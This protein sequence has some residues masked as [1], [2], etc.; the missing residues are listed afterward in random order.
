MGEK[1]ELV[2]NCI[3]I[4]LDFLKN[5]NSVKVLDIIIDI[6]YDIMRSN[7]DEKSREQKLLKVL[8][9]LKNSQTFDSM[10]EEEDR[11]VLNS[12]LGDFLQVNCDTGKYYIG[13]DN[14]KALSLEDFYYYLIELKYIKEE[15]KYKKKYII[16]YYI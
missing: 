8:Y 1:R 4:S 6:C 7:I 11:L 12:F 9:N 10:L 2:K 3:E 5:V 14:F 13:N 15:E 16:N